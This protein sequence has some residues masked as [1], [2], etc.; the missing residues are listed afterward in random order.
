MTFIKTTQTPAGNKKR[1]QVHVFTTFS[2]RVRKNTQ[3]HRRRL[4]G[5]APQNSSTPCRFVHWDSVSQTKYCCS[6]K[7]KLSG[8]PRF[9][10]RLCYWT[11]SW[12]RRP[13]LRHTSHDLFSQVWCR[14][15]PRWWATQCMA[16]ASTR[17]TTLSKPWRRSCGSTTRPTPCQQL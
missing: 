10:G 1:L 12:R 13:H 8:L 17:T 14:A 6:L 5:H 11:E 3:N 9:L 15:C 2:L 16:N 4:E 7:V